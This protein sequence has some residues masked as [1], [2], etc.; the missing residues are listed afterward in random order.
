MAFFYEALKV[1]LKKKIIV[2]G[3][4]RNYLNLFE[5]NIQ[6]SFEVG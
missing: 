2:E 5:Y 3:A 4:I 6:N 1:S